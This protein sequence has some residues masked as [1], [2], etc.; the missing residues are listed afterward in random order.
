MM[1]ISTGTTAVTGL[2]FAP[3]H[4][5]FVASLVTVV[6]VVTGIIAWID[7]RI[8]TKI[9]THTVQ[10]VERHEAIKAAII[11]SHNT[12]RKEITHLRELLA[13]RFA[14]PIATPPPFK[15]EE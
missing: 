5:A 12:T 3:E 14:L 1:V 4:L 13:V 7:K 9:E 11:T 10:D 15:E 2:A 8:D 6:G